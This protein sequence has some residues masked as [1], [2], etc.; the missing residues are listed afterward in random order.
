MADNALQG[1]HATT[2]PADSGAGGLPQFD[3]A[4]WPGQ[5]VWM[6]IIFG[7]MFALFAKVFVPSVGGTIAH[8]EDRISGDVGE[9]RRLRDEADAQAAAAAAE[10][11]QARAQAQKLALDAKAKAK[12]EAAA[13]EA[14]EEAKLATT[15]SHAEAAINRTRE[16]AMGHVR[17]I[18]ADTAQAIVEKLTGVSLSAAELA[19]LNGQA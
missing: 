8:R 14:A 9:A 4:Q 13:R 5:M 10:T 1:T 3:L 19:A 16:A 2:A 6:L 17:E 7:V 12:A 15:L 18:A 11:A